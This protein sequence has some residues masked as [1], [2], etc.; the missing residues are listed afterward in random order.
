M[1][2]PRSQAEQHAILS[3]QVLIQQEHLKAKTGTLFVILVLENQ[4]DG[5]FIIVSRQLPASVLLIMKK[6]YRD[7]KPATS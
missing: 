1:N 5:S 6:L 4:L 7:G 2:L 3:T